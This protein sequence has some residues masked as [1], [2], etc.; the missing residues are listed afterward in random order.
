MPGIRVLDW[1]KT[2]R[3]T[4]M[5]ASAALIALA[6][7]AL[8]AAHAG[9]LLDVDATVGGGSA[10][11]N[12]N[13]GSIGA[14]VNAS[15]GGTTRVDATVGTRTG[16]VVGSTVKANL[17][18]TSTASGATARADVADTIHAK[19]RLLGPKRLLKL[20]VT[21]GAKGCE[22]A[23]RN[24]QLALVDAKVG[25]MSSEQL[26]SACVAVGGGCGGEPAS[27]A[28]P[29]AT[30]PPASSGS[31]AG[32]VAAPASKGLKPVALAAGPDK[33]R[34]MRITCRS[35]LASPARFETGL[36]KLCRKIGQ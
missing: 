8:P 35:V 26:A 17:G 15:V 21:V 24:R 29:P 25:T 27:A 20:C 18:S 34:D 32:K 5:M 1:R 23:S 28:P 31:G 33:D 22:G 4:Q 30:S 10:N 13:V 3:L 19:A 9:G 36:V 7:T 16:T 14:K 11:V 2:M 12:A 6:A